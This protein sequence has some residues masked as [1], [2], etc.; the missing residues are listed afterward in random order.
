[1]LD[2]LIFQRKH[3][4]RIKRMI[5]KVAQKL[6]YDVIEFVVQEKAFNKIEVIN[7]IRINLFWL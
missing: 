6:N 1:M 7:N 3:L 2:T 5:K 4:K